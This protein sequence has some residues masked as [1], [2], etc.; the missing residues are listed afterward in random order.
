MPQHDRHILFIDDDS[1]TLDLFKTYYEPRGYK[2]STFSD[3]N[4]T[5]RGVE[6][7]KNPLSQYDLILTD[8]E[9]PDMN[10]LEL[11]KT[12][13]VRGATAPIILITAHADVDLAQKAISAG[14]F[15]FMIK[16]IHFPQ[17]TFTM[18]RAFRFN[19]AFRSNEESFQ[20]GILCGESVA[21]KNVVAL[22]KKVANTDAT[23]LIT[24][25]SGTGKE[26]LARHIHNASERRDK[27]FIAINCSAIPDALLE[28]ELF[29]HAKG[30]YTGAHEKKIGLFEEANKGTLFLD[31]IGDLP[32]HLQAKLLRVLQDKKVK[33][34]GENHYR[35]IDTRIIAATHKNLNEEVKTNRFREDLFFRINV[36]PIYIPPLRERRTD[37]IPLAQFF[38]KRKAASSGKSY[39]FSE[40]AL[41]KLVEMEWRGNV[42]E[43]ENVI[44]RAVIFAAGNH[45]TAVELEGYSES[46]EPSKK[47]FLPFD[48]TAPDQ[49]DFPTLHELDL[50]YIQFVLKKVGW[51]KE[52][53]AH[54]LDIDRKTLYRK[55]QEIQPTSS[56]S[57]GLI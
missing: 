33:R 11:I 9:L 20:S 25:E 22:A 41:R 30:S 39:S 54:I 52:R 43:L 38:L 55:I 26:V 49:D 29:G 24:G 19:D 14:A 18:Q 47:L 23:V 53:A 36:I 40:D 27:E 5:L 28:S 13:R 17:L 37:I 10:G 6:W 2:F 3:A 46:P 16:P 35:S 56:N 21:Y 31:E 15:D 7:S 44:E 50:Q 34:V 32:L 8:Y 51:V 57:A 48:F 12:L 1:S 4:S 45:I 42:R